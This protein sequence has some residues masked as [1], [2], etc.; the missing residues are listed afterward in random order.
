MLERIVIL[1]S[2]VMG[3]GSAAL[4]ASHGLPTTIVA[5]TR[6][7]ALAGKAAAE[8]LAK[9][10][11]VIDVA[12]YDAIPD[13]DFILECVA[14]DLATKRELFAG[15]EGRDA[16]IASVSSGLSI[17]EMC[18]DRSLAFKARFL[19]VHLFNPPTQITGCELIAH[20]LTSEDTLDAVRVLLLRVK[21]KIVETADT[22]GF[23]GNRVGFRLLNHVAQLAEEHGVAFMDALLGPHTGRVLA[24]L[25]TIDLVGWDVHAAICDHLHAHSGDPVFAVPDY[26]RR[27]IERGHLGR[28]THELGG[29]YRQSQVLDPGSGEYEPKPSLV[30]AQIGRMQGAPD[31]EALMRLIATDSSHE[32]CLLRSVLL[33]YVSHGLSLVGEVVNEPADIDRIM[34]YGFSWASPTQLVEAIGA[35]P[36]IELLAKEGLAVPAVLHAA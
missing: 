22:P 23:A 34:G 4:F 24:P 20:S 25:A 19:G 31:L 36:M 27:G 35:E 2:G 1:G 32:A 18:A 14:E 16:I 13:A 9:Q 7:K 30:P 29:F 8:R 12:T 33:S 17:T 15:L 5:R 3:A 21:R 10:P 26:M 28:K 6:E 11:L